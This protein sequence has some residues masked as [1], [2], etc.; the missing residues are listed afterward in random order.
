MSIFACDQD[1][2]LSLCWTYHVNASQ[3]TI[4]INYE[5]HPSD[6]FRAMGRHWVGEDEY[7]YEVSH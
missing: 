1:S 3:L 7:K 6:I 4:N 2:K 5:L